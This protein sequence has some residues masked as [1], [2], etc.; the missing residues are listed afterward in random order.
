MHPLLFIKTVKLSD[1]FHLFST[2]EYIMEISHQTL[3]LNHHKI[4]LITPAQGLIKLK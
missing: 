2:Y 1:S 4:Y 3:H